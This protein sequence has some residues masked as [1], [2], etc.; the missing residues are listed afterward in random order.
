MQRSEV[1][2][3]RKPGAASALGERSYRTAG[4]GGRL[5]AREGGAG[6][7]DGGALAMGGG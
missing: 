1:R 2:K 4:G 6:E 3:N 5:I 7:G